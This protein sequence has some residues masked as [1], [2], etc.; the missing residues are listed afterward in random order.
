MAEF[1]KTSLPNTSHIKN[2][3]SL[4]R[5]VKDLFDLEKHPLPGIYVKFNEDCLDDVSCMIIGPDNTPYEGGFY[6]FKITMPPT[7]PSVPPSVKFMTT[8]GYIRFHPNLYAC[9]KVCLSILGTW[10]GP[11]W[12]PIMSLKSVLLSLQSLLGYANP[13]QCEPGFENEKSTTVRNTNFNTTVSYQN[14]KFAICSMVDQPVLSEFKSEIHS[15]YRENIAKYNTQLQR[16]QSIQ[17]EN[18]KLSH[19]NPNPNLIIRNLYGLKYECDFNAIT[20]PN[21][22]ELQN[23]LVDDK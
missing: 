4:K 12:L 6:F 13:I 5:I 15:F 18:Q 16:F 9:G 19:T 2:R 10:E 1:T 8:D 23:G 11:S 17:T 21:I 7:Y 20:L 3:S 14:L 22:S